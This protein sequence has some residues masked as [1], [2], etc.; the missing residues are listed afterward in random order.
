MYVPDRRFHSF[1]TLE[2]RRS[3]VPSNIKIVD[4]RILRLSK[5]ER[6]D[7]EVQDGFGNSKILKGSVGK[8][9]VWLEQS[10]SAAIHI[11]S[12]SPFKFVS[13]RR[14]LLYLFC[15]C[16]CY[17]SPFSFV[18]CSVSFP[19]SSLLNSWGKYPMTMHVKISI[20]DQRE[21]GNAHKNKVFRKCNWRYC[22]VGM[23]SRWLHINKTDKVSP[24]GTY[25]SKCPPPLPHQSLF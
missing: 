18:S 20:G 10:A 2:I 6:A 13:Q 25:V 24:L 11:F 19:V 4:P 5:C 14:R 22:R 21:W 8:L 7:R 12:F 1:R 17:L 3:T 9:A 16:Y 23:W 15:C